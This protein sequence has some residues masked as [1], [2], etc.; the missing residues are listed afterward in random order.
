MSNTAAADVVHAEEKYTR[1]KS[2]IEL[3]REQLRIW[4]SPEAK[5]ADKSG[6]VNPVTTAQAR[7][8]IEKGLGI[9]EAALSGF[10]A[11]LVAARMAARTP[12]YEPEKIMA[13]VDFYR[14]AGSP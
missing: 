14:K 11:D 6:Y 5:H 8:S 4:D 10:A 1:C 13:A 7:Y 2:R 9:N 12:G 3:A